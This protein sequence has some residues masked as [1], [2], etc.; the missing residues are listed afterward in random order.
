MLGLWLI[1]IYKVFKSKKHEF[2]EF[3]YKNIEKAHL[4]F[5]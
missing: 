4:S 1:K 2:E 5:E 3:S